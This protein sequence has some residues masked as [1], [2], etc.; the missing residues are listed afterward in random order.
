[1]SFV[2][3]YVGATDPRSERVGIV[4]ELEAMNVELDYEVLKFGPQTWG[5]R[6][7]IAYDG[8]VL[9]AIF[10]SEREAWIALS[11]LHPNHERGVY[12]EMIAVD[13]RGGPE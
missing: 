11:P 2:T 6:G 13:H 1:M 8:D 7:H 5:I 3:K 12:V 10:P 4:S 9:A